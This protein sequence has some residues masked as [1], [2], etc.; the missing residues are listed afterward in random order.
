F[1]CPPGVE[2]PPAD[3]HR[4]GLADI[5]LV[6]ARDGFESCDK[7]IA[8]GQ[9]H[10]PAGGS[11]C[12]G[13]LDG[14]NDA[15]KS[16]SSHSVTSPFIDIIKRATAMKHAGATDSSGMLNLNVA[17]FRARLGAA[18]SRGTDYPGTTSIRQGRSRRTRS[19]AP[20]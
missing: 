16:S 13:K 8:A 2:D 12:K 18:A 5:R 11:H 1:L 17:A 10:M 6:T 14:V 20:V 7:L 3:L 9:I 4:S 19:L 15:H